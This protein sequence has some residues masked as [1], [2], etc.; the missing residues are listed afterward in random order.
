[1]TS[2]ITLHDGSTIPQVGFGTLNLQPDRSPTPENIETTASIVRQAMDVGFRHVDT[3]QMYGTETGIGRAIGEGTIPRGE[4]YLTSKLANGN[5]RP[6]DVRSSYDETLKNLGVDQLD[7][8]LMHWPLPT[9]YDGDFV[10]T[11]R[12][13]TE[14][15][16]DGRLRS[17][18]VSNF[19]A[20]HL[21]R[22]IKDVGIVP[23]VNQI[24]VHPYFANAATCQ[25]T[26]AHGI[27]I[28]AW[29]PLGQGKELHDPVIAG[30]ATAHR[31][32]PA[33]V[34]LRWH[35]AHGRVVIPKSTHGDRMRE[36][37]ESARVELTPED[38][39]TIDALD[40]GEA[41]RVGPDPDTFDWIP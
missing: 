27:A 1:V 35:L 28:E 13:M 5:H 4:L 2:T 37:L 8:F 14:L 26:A 41:G 6:D 23:V 12:A 33:Q 34:I 36:N 22:I 21:D 24:E 31:A 38:I 20:H 25:A 40:Q 16:A 7:L 39:A 9:R 18:G 10:S 17:A 19:L 32:T 3:A 29:S 15:V 11:W 30:I